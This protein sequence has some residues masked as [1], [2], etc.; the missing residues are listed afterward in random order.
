MKKVAVVSKN[1]CQVLA[2]GAKYGGGIV[3]TGNLIRA[4]ANMNDVELT[5]FTEID[6]SASIDNVRVIEIPYP[7]SSDSYIDE[8]DKIVKKEN[9]DIVLSANIPQLYHTCLLQC[10]SPQYKCNNLPFLLRNLKKVFGRK[11]LD[12]SIKRFKNIEDCR[13]IAVSEIIKK[14]YQENF[15]IPSERIRDVYP[16]CTKVFDTL[17]EIKNN[18]NITFGIVANSSFNKGGNLLL[19]VLGLLKLC[20]YNFRVKIIA[21]KF[22]RDFVMQGLVNVFGMN[23]CVEAIP[24]QSDM[25]GFYSTIDVLVLPSIN[26]AFGLVVLE[27]MAFGKPCIVSSTAGIAEIINSQNGFV[28]NRRKLSDFIQTIIKVIK[29]YNEEF[30]RFKDYCKNAFET[31]GIY[32]WEK[33]ARKILESSSADREGVNRY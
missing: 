11:K 15:N 27:A 12:W 14:D 8:I 25:K 17:P 33:F 5:V 19:F 6:S 28:F 4:Y 30:S 26:E 2:G 9:F 13:F 18:T 10:H 29:I 21:P 1:I 31:S 7:Y 22:R 3:V 23:K 20:G 16:A 24:K 32:T